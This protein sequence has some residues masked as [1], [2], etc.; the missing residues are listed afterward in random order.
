MS[1]FLRYIPPEAREEPLRKTHDY[2]YQYRGYWDDDGICRIRIFQDVERT[3]VIV[4]SQL[5]ENRST[6]ITNMAEHLAAEVVAKHLPQ[7]FEEDDPFLW[8]EEYPP[9]RRRDPGPVFTA[10]HFASYTP[11]RER[12]NGVERVTLGRPT[13]QP[14]AREAVARLIGYAELAPSWWEDTP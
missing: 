12:F 9:L 10:V 4:A 5:A 1:E 2:R 14:I 7:R 6:S 3:P 11:R 13:W 8:L